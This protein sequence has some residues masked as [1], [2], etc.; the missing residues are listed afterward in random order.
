MVRAFGEDLAPNQ[1]FEFLESGCEPKS[2]A[3]LGCDHQTIRHLEPTLRACKEINYLNFR[4]KHVEKLCNLIHRGNSSLS[5]LMLL[6]SHTNFNSS[7]KYFLSNR[8][9][10]FKPVSVVVFLIKFIRR[11]IAI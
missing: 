2:S 8:L 4:L 9:W 6:N 11:F 7:P 5:M 1:L 3:A 10:T